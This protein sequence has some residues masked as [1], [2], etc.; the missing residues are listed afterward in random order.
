M[1]AKVAGAALGA[2]AVLVVVAAGTATATAAPTVTVHADQTIVSVHR[3]SIGVNTPIW[4]GHLVDSGVPRLIQQA[5]FGELEFNGGGVMDLYHWR[6]GTDSPDPEKAEHPIDYSSIPPLFSFDKFEHVAHQ[7][8]AST[9]VHVNYGTGTPQEAAGWVR[10]ANLVRHDNVRDWA[11]GE[12]VYGNGGLSSAIDF[13]P[14]AHQDKSAA[15]YGRNVVAFA[16]AMKAVDPTIHVGIELAPPIAGSPL[17]D[18]DR[19]VLTTAGRAVDFVDLHWY[20]YGPQ[21]DFYTPVRDIPATLA[22]TRTLVDPIVGP[23]VRIVVGETNSAIEAG[24]QQ[25]SESNAVYLA[26]DELSLLEN[27]ASSVDWWDLHNGSPNNDVDLG[28]LSSGA[29]LSSGPGPQPTDVPF[30]PYYGQVLT[31]ELAR[32]GSS[33]VKVDGVTAPVYVHAARQPNGD[34]VVLLLNEDSTHNATINLRVAGYR[35]RPTAQQSSLSGLGTRITK[36]VVS[37][38]GTKTLPP[39]SLTELVLHRTNWSG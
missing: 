7:A 39:D 22:A 25:T 12:E 30:A 8:G 23:H 13:E 1:R 4:N 2:A 35:A 11:I 18:W 28:L 26:D 21:P 27:G 33:L 16:K 5:G 37:A 3:D 34:L 10:Y 36:A 20:P 6:D 9:L 31:S 17:L 32:P 38:T 19:T 24:T 29:T 15:A 14:D